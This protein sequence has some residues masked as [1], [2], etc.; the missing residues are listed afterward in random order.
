MDRTTA[1]YCLNMVVPIINWID[2]RQVQ[3]NSIWCIDGGEDHIGPRWIKDQD[4]LL[5]SSGFIRRSEVLSNQKLMNRTTD[6][7]DLNDIGHHMLPNYSVSR[8]ELL[9]MK[10]D[11]VPGH[12]VGLCDFHAHLFINRYESGRYPLFHQREH[13]GGHL[14]Y[15]LLTI[16]RLN[17][18]H[19]HVCF[20]ELIACSY[21]KHTFSMLSPPPQQWISSLLNWGWPDSSSSS[22]SLP[23]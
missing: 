19:L 7:I 15:V 6:K 11:Y 10:R 18:S 20:P 1:I 14:M 13:S 16:T 9:T 12:M 22:S 21:Y 2:I 4:C 17:F 5:Y 23:L 3:K 8:R